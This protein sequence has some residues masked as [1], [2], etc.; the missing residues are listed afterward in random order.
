VLALLFGS[1]TVAS[2][3]SSGPIVSLCRS[4]ESDSIGRRGWKIHPTILYVGERLSRGGDVY[5]AGP[6][7][8]GNDERND[9][10]K[11]QQQHDEG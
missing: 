7:S 4:N 9:D 1:N 11:Q 6:A 5:A 8:K 10:G 2:A 3:Y